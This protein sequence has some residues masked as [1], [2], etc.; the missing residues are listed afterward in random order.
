MELTAARK[1]RVSV[2]GLVKVV[3]PTLDRGAHERAQRGDHCS[4]NVI[5]GGHQGRLGIRPFQLARSRALSTSRRRSVGR[6]DPAVAAVPTGRIAR[7]GPDVFFDRERCA[8][9]P[10]ARARQC[11]ATRRADAINGAGTKRTRIDR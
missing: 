6:Y 1:G 7:I 8:P 3:T 5:G 2:N 9:D 10:A 4:V 11:A